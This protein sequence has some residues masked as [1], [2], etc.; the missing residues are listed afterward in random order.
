M[1]GKEERT[2]TEEMKNADKQ[3]AETGQ[4]WGLRSPWDIGTSDIRTQTPRTEHTGCSHPDK[5]LSDDENVRVDQVQ[6]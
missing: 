5:Y 6:T 3:G 4:R 1:T 2:K